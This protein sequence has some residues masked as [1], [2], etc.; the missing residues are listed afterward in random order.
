MRSHPYNIRLPSTWNELE[1]KDIILELVPSWSRKGTKLQTLK[2]SDNQIVTKQE[3]SKC[4][5]LGWIQ[6]LRCLRSPNTY[7]NSLLPDFYLFMS[8]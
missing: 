8:P 4:T 2:W 6:T 5:K 1:W 3:N 7:Q